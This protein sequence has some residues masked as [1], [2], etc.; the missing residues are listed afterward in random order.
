MRQGNA[1]FA[2]VDALVAGALL[3][4]GVLGLAQVVV[5]SA[6]AVTAARQATMATILAA[7]KVEELRAGVFATTEGADVSG[8]FRRAWRVSAYEDDPADTL[9]VV[10]TVMPGRVRFVTLRT[11]VEP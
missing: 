2:L 5:M 8:E 10:V 9:V 1:G 7:Q 11:R 6:G 4:T 3:A